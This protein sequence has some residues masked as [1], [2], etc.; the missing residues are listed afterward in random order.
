MADIKP[1]IE[2]SFNQYAGAVLQSRALIDS[3]D[4]IKPSARQI[5]YSMLQR[6]LTHDKPHKKTANAVG[7]AMADYYIHGDSSCV[8]VIMRAGQDFSMRYPLI[9]IK[10]NMGSL[11]ES[12]NWAADRYTE[13]RTSALMDGIFSDIDKNTIDDWRDNYDNTKQYPGVLP[14]KGYYNICN[15]S[16]GIGVGMSS[17]IPQFNLREVNKALETLLLN[18]TVSDD[19]I[20]PMPDFATGACLLNPTEVKA[21]L[22][23]GN[24]KACLLRAVINYDN[25]ENCLVVTEIPYSV[26]TN[27]ICGELD[28]ILE[29]EDNPGIDRYNDLTGKTPLIKIYLTKNANAQIVLKYLYKNTSLQYWYSINM[30]MLENGRYPRLFTW[31][32]A[33]QSHIEHEKIVYRR[34]F[35]YDKEKAEARLHIVEGLLIARANIDEVIKIIKNAANPGNAKGTLIVI[36]NLTDIQAQAILDMRLSRLTHLE[37]EKLEKEKC[38]LIDEV[39]KIELILSNEK[40]FNEH[41]V[42]GW[43]SVAEKYG[44]ERRTKITPMEEEE[45]PKLNNKDV[46]VMITEANEIIVTDHF[47]KTNT[48][49]KTSDFYKTK[50]KDGYQTKLLNTI[51]AYD[52]QGR[53]YPIDVYKCPMTMTA[54]IIGLFDIKDKRYLIYV[55]N[56]GTVKKSLITEYNGFKRNAMLGKIREDEK[57]V[58][59]SAVT[60]EEYLFMLGKNGKVSK[61]SINDFTATGKSTIGT[62]GMACE[63]ISATSG[64][65]EVN[66]VAIGDEKYKVTVGS[67]YSIGGKNGLGYAVAENTV[68]LFAIPKN[69]FY[70]IENGSKITYFGTAD[71]SVKG[72]GAQGNKTTKEVNIIW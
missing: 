56:K 42:R 51:Y 63:V 57:V 36:F 62:K 35:E 21:S 69:T 24:G 59:A 17:S 22:K 72:K 27:T 53:I 23:N 4:C 16:F 70:L 6:K 58:Y 45:A 26:Y 33:L 9:D 48:A 2:N 38:A 12:G 5:F 55:T 32:E 64:T 44:D 10:G 50:F 66:I 47:K 14:S 37:V 54:N 18:P 43:R 15:G 13:S 60:N 7:M 65:D 39:R 68:K 30:T 3:R 31:R 67:D 52:E 20:I 46:V 25:K 19:E 34:G 8:G 49:L 11:A 41:L 1:I 28:A 61:V 40:I 71:Y 29:K